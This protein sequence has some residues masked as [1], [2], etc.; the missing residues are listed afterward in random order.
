VGIQYKNPFCLSSS[1]VTNSA[2]MI[3]RAYDAGFAGAYYKTLNREDQFFVSHPSPRLNSVNAA[4][5]HRHTGG[6]ASSAGA[7]M[8]VGIQN[9]EQISD[10]P[11]ADNLADIAWLRK[12]YPEHITAASI[13][14]FC[15]EDWAYLA[16]AAEGAGAHLLE[17]NFSCPQMARSDAGHHV[18]QQTELIERFTAAAKRACN[19][20]VIAKLTPNVADMLPA[21][22]AAQ[23]GG[24]DG[25][26]TINTLKSISHID[27]ESMQAEP[28]IQGHSAVSGYSGQGA[29]P[30]GLRF[31]SD[32]GRAKELVI[33]ISGMGGIY[34]WRHA[35]EYISLGASNIQATTSVMQH[36]VRVVEDMI[37]GLQRHMQQQGVARV[38]DMVG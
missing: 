9:V 17:L 28:T 6:T 32:L 37:D 19:I 13:M 30:V 24:A 18:G 11:L 21:A 20:P 36:G 31:V 8:D 14:G 25:V 10:R 3:A 23:N 16:A 2:D 38:A 1:P 7:G 35:A 22:L 15:D 29:R 34:T 27:I 12:H 4:W 33:P 5:G 26:S